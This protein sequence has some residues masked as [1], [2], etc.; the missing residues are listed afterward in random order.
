MKVINDG[1]IT[2]VV[3]FT[4]QVHQRGVGLE[5]RVQK[6][7]ES[8]GIV[9][10]RYKRDGIDFIINGFFHIDCVATGETGS[11]DEKIPHKCRKYIKKYGLKDI[12]ILHPY[13]PIKRDVGEHLEEQE[14]LYKCNIHILDWKDFTY[15]MEGGT[16]DKRKPYNYSR[17][18]RGVSNS[19]P[20]NANLLKFFS[21]EKI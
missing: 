3:K 21:F 2:K 5:D 19:A 18:G 16:F 10:K 6:Y 17:D 9:F 4:E 15:L 8:Q 7:L 1:K 13:S 20:T 12:Y 14:I 11:I